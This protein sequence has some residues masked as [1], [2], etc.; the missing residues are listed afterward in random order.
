VPGLD[1]LKLPEKVTDELAALPRLLEIDER[2]ELLAR[3]DARED[4]L[5]LRLGRSDSRHLG[6]ALDGVR[7]R[8]S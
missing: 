1:A 3:R 4:V 5:D 2:P 6:D 8:A 7:S